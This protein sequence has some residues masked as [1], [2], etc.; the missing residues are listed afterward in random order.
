[1]DCVK[2]RTLLSEHIDGLV[3]RE[4]RAALVDHLGSCA[5]CAQE[6]NALLRVSSALKSAPRFNAPSGFSS[7]VMKKIRTEENA[8]AEGPGLF[9]WLWSMPMHLKLAEAAAVILVTVMGVYSAG[10]ISGR[11]LNGNGVS[12]QGE[13]NLLALASLDELDTVPPGSMGDM[14]LSIKE[15][16]NEQ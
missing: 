4:A 8:P 13:G 2:A 9:G 5:D 7:R 11:L 1:M 3:D 12:E 10:F 6:L 15:N 16:G 14:Y